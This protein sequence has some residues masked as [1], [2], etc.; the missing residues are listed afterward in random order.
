MARHPEDSIAWK[1][2]FKSRCLQK[3]YA[4]EDVQSKWKKFSVQ[5]LYNS[6]TSQI[7][8]SLDIKNIR[9]KQF[10]HKHAEQTEL[11]RRKE[12]ECI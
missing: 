5:H 11:L 9:I 7:I 12:A 4:K 1:W 8:K 3:F 10:G 6:D 2:P